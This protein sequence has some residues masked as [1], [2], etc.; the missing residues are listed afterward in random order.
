MTSTLLLLLF[1]IA[2]AL[3]LLLPTRWRWIVGMGMAGALGWW[4]WSLS[5]G[6]D[7]SSEVR[8]GWQ[9]VVGW[10]LALIFVTAWLTGVGVSLVLRRLLAR[11]AR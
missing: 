4:I 3:A 7:E 8:C 6:C 1:A 11:P 5:G 9:P 10:V 2:L